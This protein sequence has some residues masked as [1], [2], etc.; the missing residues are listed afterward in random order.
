MYDVDS[1]SLTCMLSMPSR[2]L[3]ESGDPDGFFTGCAVSPFKATEGE[4]FAQYAKLCRKANAGVSFVITQQGGD[5]RKY[6][7]L[8]RI[9]K[10]MNLSIYLVRFIS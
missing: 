8:T 2:R 3:Y 5:S 10:N 6:E 7:E 9:I 1:A 4:C